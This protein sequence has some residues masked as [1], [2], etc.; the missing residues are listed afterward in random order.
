[1]ANSSIDFKPSLELKPGAGSAIDLRRTE[2]V[3]VIDDLRPGCFLERDDVVQRHQTVGVRPHIILAKVARIHAEGLV[4]LHV[5]AVRAVVEVEVVHILRPHVNA[6]GLGYLADG[7]ADRFGLLTIDLHQLLWIGR[8]VAGKQS[9]KVLALAAG[10]HDLVGDVVQVLESVPAQ[11]LQLE[12]ESAEAP[13]ALIAG[14]SNATTM[15][16]GMPNSFGDT[17]ATMSLAACPLPFRSSIGFSGA[18]TSP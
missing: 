8:R 16:P 5:D 17:L 7:Y 2:Q 12:L 3:E 1:M 4:G 9:S 13:D 10:G 6:Q 18:K 11:V 15:A 14:G